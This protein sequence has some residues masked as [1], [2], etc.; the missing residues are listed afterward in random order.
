MEEPLRL[1]FNEH[2]CV[3]LV[4]YDDLDPARDRC[5]GCGLT[6]VERAALQAEGGSHD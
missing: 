2:T 6:V 5:L 4:S 1:E 3:A